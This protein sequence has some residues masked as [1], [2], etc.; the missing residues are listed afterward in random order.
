MNMSVF[1][2]NSLNNSS[3]L[4]NY[5]GLFNSLGYEIRNKL[6][7]K[8]NENAHNKTTIE[9]TTDLSNSI[10]KYYGAWQS[11]KDAGEMIEEIK[12]D[13]MN[14]QRIINFDD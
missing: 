3:L 12:A 1:S 9:S 7:E 4:E 13:R 2:A 10:N 8:L 14:S 11:D 6:L 5:I